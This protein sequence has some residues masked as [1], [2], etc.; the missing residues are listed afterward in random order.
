MEYGFNDDEYLRY[1]C[2]KIYPRIL[3]DSQLIAE[4][5]EY[6][7]VSKFRHKMLPRSSTC[8]FIYIYIW[9]FHFHYFKIIPSPVSYYCPIKRN[10]SGPT[11]REWL[12]CSVWLFKSTIWI[13]IFSSLSCCSK[14]SWLSKWDNG[15]ESCEL[16]IGVISLCIN[17]TN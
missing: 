2:R 10:Q 11:D 3:Q 4:P 1:S 14:F 13:V 9:N 7:V 17:S 6:W 8:V 5:E 12:N 16:L 15:W